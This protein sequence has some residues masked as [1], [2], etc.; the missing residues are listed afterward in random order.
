MSTVCLQIADQVGE[1]FICSEVNG[2]MRIRTPY[3][4]PDGDYI[5]LFL[6]EKDGVLTL[7]DYGET[8]RW[9]KNQTPSLYRS[10]RQDAMIQDIC[11][12]HGVELYRGMLVVR[13]QPG[14]TL[15]ETITHLAQAAIRVSDLWF[16]QRVRVFESILEE[17]GD[18]LKG[19]HIPFDAGKKYIG[20]SGRSHKIDFH[21]RHPKRSSLINVLSTGSRAAAKGRVDSAGILARPEPPESRHSIH[22]VCIFIR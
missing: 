13:N 12:T 6:I 1:L 21:T 19:K 17:V 3:L 8:L 14:T 15:A 4:Y 22:S 2:A 10:K 9:L 5:D 7:T 16:T 11:L 20:R 18:F